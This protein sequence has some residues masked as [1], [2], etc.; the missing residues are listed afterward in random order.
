MEDREMYEK[1]KEKSTNFVSYESF[2]KM[3]HETKVAAY[4]KTVG[5][6]Q[7]GAAKTKTE[8]A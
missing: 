1:I 6:A 2:R 3:K 4:K 5:A 7:E 8:I